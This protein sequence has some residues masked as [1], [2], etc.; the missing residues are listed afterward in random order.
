[1]KSNKFK[2]ASWVPNTA[3]VAAKDRP[4][5][6]CAPKPDCE[7]FINIEDREINFLNN[8]AALI[9]TKMVENAVKNS[10]NKT[11]YSDMPKII[12]IEL[13][14]CMIVTDSQ[15]P[16]DLSHVIN[17]MVNWDSR[18]W[19][20]PKGSYDP[21][22]KRYGITDGQHRIVAFR[23]L[24]RMGYF[25]N[26]NPSEWKTVKIPLE[27]IELEVYD[28][29]V[30]YGPS[31]THFLGENGE[32]TKRV[33]EM[34]RFVT[35]VAGKIIDSPGVDTKPEYEQA[36]ARYMVMKT[37]GIT[38]V[39]SKDEYNRSKAGAFSAVRLLRGKKP[40]SIKELSLVCRHHDVFSRHE[41]VADIEVLPIIT[42]FKEI[43]SYPWFDVTDTNK[44]SE[45]NKLFHYMNA[46]IYEFGDWDNF[47]HVAEQVWNERC[48]RR[49]VRESIP[50]D[51]SLSLL[52]QL[53]K[54]AGY[55]FPGIDH[56]WYKKYEF[57]SNMTLFSCLDI[58]DQEKFK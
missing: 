14:E 45:R 58:E 55:T 38:P 17:I 32:Y 10:K 37:F 43:D 49:R 40:L 15:R 4:N 53:V 7:R 54:K 6:L 33:T 23:E 57:G 41:P 25:S 16:L 42:L 39:H 30:D 8:Y 51:L 48:K 24:I 3:A 11:A 31:R 36:A 34:D 22:R 21:I 28:G 29:I 35:E 47:Q 46:V 20:T 44:V 52:L 19:R 5:D 26:I 18:N 13:G 1:M 2:F 56:E 50:A 12:Y 27:V 9:K